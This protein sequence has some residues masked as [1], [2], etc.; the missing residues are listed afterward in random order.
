MALISPN[1]FIRRVCSSRDILIHTLFFSFVLAG[2]YIENYGRSAPTRQA[3]TVVF[4]PPNESHAVDFQS[5]ARILSV[6]MSFERLA[7]IRG[8]SIV[9][10]QSA[11]SRSAVIADLGRRIH[12]EFCRLDSFSALAIE[13]L[14]FEILAE[15]SRSKIG[16]NE[17]HFPR[18]L[19]QAKDF[20][21]GN[22]SESISVGTIARVADVHPV[23]LSC[24]FREK[25]GCTV[26]EYLRRLRV[27]FAA[28]Q[29]C[30]TKIPLCEI[31]QAAGFADQSHL[32]KTFKNVFGSTP[33]EYRKFNRT[34]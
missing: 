16:A 32:N 10:D 30:K 18:W 27:E 5:G 11:S 15:A 22:F 9:F 12:R 7:Y 1:V 17:K 24:V 6:E 33:A 31:A 29:I 4:H 23:Y 25:F 28:E 14:I 2:E 3:S 13:G 26:G 8:H 19:E 21:H 20:L 34:K